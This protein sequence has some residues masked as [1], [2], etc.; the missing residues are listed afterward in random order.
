MQ[1]KF[2]KIVFLNIAFRDIMNIMKK[3]LYAWNN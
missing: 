1:Y 3:R 2:V